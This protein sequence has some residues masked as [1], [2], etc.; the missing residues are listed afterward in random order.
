MTESHIEEAVAAGVRAADTSFEAAAETAVRLEE[1]RSMKPNLDQLRELEA[2][3]GARIIFVNG[4]AA[5]GLTLPIIPLTVDEAKL[6]H[7]VLAQKAKAIEEVRKENEKA[8]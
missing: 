4:G 5:S 3:L 6:V 8:A 2:D 7:S 1:L